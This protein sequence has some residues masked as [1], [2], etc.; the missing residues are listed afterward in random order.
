MQFKATFR[1]PVTRKLTAELVEA[2]T[3]DAAMD[4]IWDKY[5]MVGSLMVSLVGSKPGARWGTK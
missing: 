5:G 1:H 3:T 4:R 2:Q